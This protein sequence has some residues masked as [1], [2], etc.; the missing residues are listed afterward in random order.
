[1]VLLA[2]IY[3]V[4]FPWVLKPV[5]A[6]IGIRFADCERYGYSGFGFSDI[7]WDNGALGI[8]AEI[9]DWQLRITPPESPS[10]DQGGGMSGLLDDFQGVAP[11]LTDWLDWLILTNGRINVG[12][13]D[14]PVDSVTLKAGQV[15][16]EAFKTRA[17]IDLT[18]LAKASLGVTVSNSVASVDLGLNREG[19][20]WAFEGGV[21]WSS[22]RFELR[23]SFDRAHWLP[24]AAVLHS[25]SLQVPLSVE[26]RPQRTDAG[27][28]RVAGS[29]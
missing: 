2:L 27:A 1:L 18:S 4:W 9:R 3:P 14:Y 10:Q 7:R 5:V 19:S 23:G 24:A 6:R 25:D 29:G 22:N 12:A 26:P 21:L 8:H 13:K 17:T 11:A 28:D 20:R 15:R 16:V